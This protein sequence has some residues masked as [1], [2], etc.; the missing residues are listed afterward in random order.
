MAETTIEKYIQV[1]RELPNEVKRKIVTSDDFGVGH[2]L[3]LLRLKDNPGLIV[4]T[5][6]AYFGEQAGI[7]IGIT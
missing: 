1:A 7:W 5:I 4:F 2:A 6:L 3:Q